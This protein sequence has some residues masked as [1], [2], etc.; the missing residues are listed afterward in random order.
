MLFYLFR[1]RAIRFITAI[2]VVAAFAV[3]SSPSQGAGKTPEQ[4]ASVHSRLFRKGPA[5]GIT[6]MLSK[7]SG[8]V[9]VACLVPVAQQVKVKMSFTEELALF[10]SDSDLVVLGK[11][12]AGTTHVN[13]VTDFAGFTPP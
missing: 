5:G 9:H 4:I 7:A 13:A 3:G 10:A 11:A 6:N 8:D 2:L 12:E 1:C